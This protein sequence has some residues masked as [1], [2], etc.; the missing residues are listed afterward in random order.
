MDFLPAESDC[1]YQPQIEV[2]G[3]LAHGIEMLNARVARDGT[4]EFDLAS[5]AKLRRKM[6]EE[7]AEHDDDDTKGSIRPQKAIADVR[8]VLGPHDILLSGVGAHKMWV[9]RHYQCQEPGTCL[10]SN[11]FCSMGMPLPGAISA[12]LSRPDAKIL[13]VVG[14]G[15]VM[16]NVQEMETASRL[17]SDITVL[18]WEDHAYGLITWK[19]QQE[20]GHHTDLS[21]TNPDWL[22]L[23]AAMGWQGER[24]ENAADLHDALNRALAHKGPAMVVIPIDYRENMILTE[25][26]GK[27]ETTF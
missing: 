21:F 1:N 26:L 12:K 13:A 3:D 19:Q 17:N 7:F 20:F 23:C 4:P 8:A 14:D 15:D 27:I 11:G 10:I 16:M 25:R 9:A 6:L 18:V 5:Q 2:V 24:C 22:G